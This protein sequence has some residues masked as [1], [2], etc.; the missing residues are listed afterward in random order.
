MAS[1]ESTTLCRAIDI[2]DALGAAARSGQPEVGVN[3]VA[4][5]VGYEKSQ[6]SRSLKTLASAGLVE[7]NPDT[8]GYRVGWKLFAL[9]EVAGDRRLSTL[10]GPVLRSLVARTGEP[11]YLTV[12]RGDHVLTVLSEQSSAPIQVTYWTGRCSP[13]YSTSSGQALLMQHDDADIRLMLDGV[14]FAVS[15]PNGPRDTD[16][17]L[18]R[19]RRAR[20]AGYALS[21]ED[22]D[23]GLVA[24]AAP[25]RDRRRRIVGA[26]N[27]SAPK[28]RLGPRLDWAGRQVKAAAD[29]LSALITHPQPPA[30]LRQRATAGTRWPTRARPRRTAASRPRQPWNRAPRHTVGPRPFPRPYRHVR[31]PQSTR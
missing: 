16:A 1:Q 3:E 12:L 27:V 4:R 14:P 5:L 18:D 7:R 26:L 6:V 25:V 13:V 11:A 19:L 31:T 9:A 28:F 22:F 24:A 30:A 10:A 2:M 20:S 8:L 15:G 23:T 21:D 17:L 29:H